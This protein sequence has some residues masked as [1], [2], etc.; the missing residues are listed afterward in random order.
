MLFVQNFKRKRKFVPMHDTKNYGDNG[1][2]INTL[3]NGDNI[4]TH[5]NGNN[6]N[7]HYNGDNINTHYNGDNINTHYNGLF[8][9]LYRASLTILYCDQQMHGHLTNYH[10]PL[11][12]DTIV[13]SSGS[14]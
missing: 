5:Y 9:Y 14:L 4:N 3:Y 2:N 11:C 7:T 1:D 6:I 13:S 10:T 12:F 8:Q